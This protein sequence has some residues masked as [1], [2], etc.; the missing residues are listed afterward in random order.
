MEP[1]ALSSMAVFLPRSFADRALLPSTM[2]LAMLG[3]QSAQAHDVVRAQVDASGGAS[4]SDECMDTNDSCRNWAA[5]GECSSNPGFMRTACRESCSMSRRDEDCMAGHSG[6]GGEACP[7][8]WSSLR[9][10][11]APKPAFGV[12]PRGPQ[13]EPAC[14]RHIMIGL[15]SSA[16]RR[17]AATATPPARR[18]PRQESAPATSASW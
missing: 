8:A 1:Q 13:P 6:P 7:G 16:N 9:P 17:R 3:T 14:F 12:P 11:L 5:D 18:G 10:D 4:P 2:L 15:A